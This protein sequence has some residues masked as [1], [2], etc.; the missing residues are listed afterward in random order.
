MPGG[1]R[2]FSR[3]QASNG[4]GSS[5]NASHGP[6]DRDGNLIPLASLVVLPKHSQLPDIPGD[7][8]LYF[9]CMLFVFGVIMMSLQYINLYKTVWWLPQ[10]HAQYALNFYLIDFYL[11]GFICIVLSTRLLICLV[12]E[13]QG[14][15][16]FTWFLQMFKILLVL[17]AVT[18]F[19]FT[20][21]QVVLEHGPKTCLFLCYPAVIYLVLF[22]LAIKPLYQRYQAW[23]KPAYGVDRQTVPAKCKNKEETS[24][25][26]TCTLTPDVV[27]E[28][29]DLL[30]KDFNCRLKQ[31]L[32]N[33]LTTS[34]YATGVPVWFS[35][36]TLYYDS[37]WMWQHVCLTWLSAVLMLTCHFLPPQYLHLLHKS[38]RHLGRWQRME[39]RH[40]HVPYN[41]W[42]EL[43]V[44]PQGALVKHV[45]GLFKA[46]GINVT[47]E[48]GNSLHSRFYML[49]HQPMRV[50]N[51]LVFLTC[52]VVGYQFFCLVQSSEWSHVV[53][54]ALLMFC[55]FY[56]LFKLMR[57]WFI[58]GKVYKDHDY[59]LTN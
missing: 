15:K 19:C 37:L 32:F 38:A 12:Q 45:R 41:A 43:Q 22:G 35:Q 51:W 4:K 30:K 21:Y 44:W 27:R 36:N 1:R 53:S 10:S 23:P 2:I 46:E 6:D 48:P 20:I 33:S 54:L 56:T 26:H 18:G 7:G 24:L 13:V 25:G 59:G 16:L 58:M 34:F 17:G 31:V 14:I 9:E 39:A 57:D 52:L 5:T 47:A 49:F 11:V 8:N 55:N 50:M 29:V 40:A 42:S 3:I 28:E